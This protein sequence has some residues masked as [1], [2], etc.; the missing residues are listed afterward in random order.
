MQK[1]TPQ[2]L[3]TR[4]NVAK[5]NTLKSNALNSNAKNTRDKDEKRHFLDSYFYTPTLIQKMLAFLLLPC[6]FV[7][8]CIASLKAGVARRL[9]SFI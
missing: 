2:N 3:S 8:F 4:T 7:Y 6:S 5:P 1:K 9:L